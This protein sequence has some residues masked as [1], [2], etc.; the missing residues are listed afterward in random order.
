[1]AELGKITPAEAAAA[2]RQGLGLN[3]RSEPGGCAESAYPF[4][5][6]YV[7]HEILANPAF[8]HSRADRER[9]LQRGG[10]TLKTTLDAT[11]QEAADKA[12]RQ[13]VAAED[14]EVAAEAMVEPGTGRIR[15]LAASKRYGSNPGGKV[16]GPNTTFNLPADT[17][18]GGGMGFQAGSTFKI[19]TL[20]T[21]LAKGWRFGQ[22]FNTPRCVRAVVGLHRLRREAGQRPQRQDLQRLRR[23]LGRALQPGAGD[24][25]VVQHLLHDAGE[26]GRALRRHP[27]RQGA[28]HPA[29]GR[30]QA[31]GG[32]DVHARGQRDGPADG[33]RR[34]SRRSGRAAS[35]ASRWPSPRS[36]NA[37][38]GG[39]RSRRAARPPST[40]GSPTRST[41]CSPGC[42]PRAR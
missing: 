25:E 39:W 21:A 24:V 15:A 7:Q 36:S 11:A 34:P 2:K 13:R 6:V 18:H 12:I 32:A 17:A 38:G 35:T 10:L 28:G 19:F 9:R 3:M 41:T 23:G 33:G 5:C 30:R 1:M 22:G 40:R 26:G 20:A 8:G 37:T 29:G 14:T 31:V 27:D 16:T 42:S 4:F